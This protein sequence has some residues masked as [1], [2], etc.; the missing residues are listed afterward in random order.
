MRTFSNY[1]I[2]SLADDSFT[3]WP[4]CL[5]EEMLPITPSHII[6]ITRSFTSR[7]HW[8]P[9]SLPASFPA[10]LLDSCHSFCLSICLPAYLP[11]LLD[12]DTIYRIGELLPVIIT[13]ESVYFFSGEGPAYLFI[14]AFFN[15]RGD[16]IH[17]T[18]FIFDKIQKIHH[19]CV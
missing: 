11:C 2:C 12:V 3:N 17:F 9:R 10:C 5:R 19:V 4:E 14:N 6:P 13:L 8:E 18:R 1:K 15:F 16:Y 7:C